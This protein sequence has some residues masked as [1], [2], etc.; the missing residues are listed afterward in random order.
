M[1]DPKAFTARDNPL[2]RAKRLNDLRSRVDTLEA[3]KFTTG[4]TVPELAAA[5]VANPP[6]GSQTLF[7]DTAD[8]KLKRKDSSGTVT[9]IA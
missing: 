4:I 2:D 8:H 6:A 5:S 1:A 9:I 7:I 3:G